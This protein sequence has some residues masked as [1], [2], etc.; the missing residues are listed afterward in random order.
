MN[1]KKSIENS[2]KRIKCRIK[3]KKIFN[4]YVFFLASEQPLILVGG[5]FLSST[6]VKHEVIEHLSFI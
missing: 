6:M 1:F 4:I 5:Q 2:I 3:K